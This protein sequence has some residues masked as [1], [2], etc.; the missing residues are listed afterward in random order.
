MVEGFSRTIP[1]EETRQEM[2]RDKFI[3]A[4]IEFSPDK[5]M[6]HLV[7]DTDGTIYVDR[8]KMIHSR[9][10]EPLFFYILN[11]DY[12]A[13][14]KDIEHLTP[15]FDIDGD[16]IIAGG[17]N[18]VTGEKTSKRR[19]I[20]MSIETPYTCFECDIER[21]KE[22]ITATQNAPQRAK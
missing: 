22:I 14:W 12:I 2:I 5:M 18:I 9:E 1:D 10:Q 3:R 20:S 17:Y 6:K 7:R 15:Y 16:I 11:R 19:L 13:G 8:S 4:C 21:Y